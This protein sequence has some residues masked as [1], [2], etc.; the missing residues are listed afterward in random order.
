MLFTSTW[1]ELLERLKGIIDKSP[2]E[3]RELLFDVETRICGD[4]AFA[5]TPF[6]IDI[7]GQTV[8]KGVN[9]FTLVRKEGGWIIS[10]CQDT[11]M[12]V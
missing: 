1:A 10:G 5:W 12:P 9:I 3:I 2:S 7:N 8:N 4:F 11:S 6:V